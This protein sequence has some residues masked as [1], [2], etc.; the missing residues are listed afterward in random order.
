METSRTRLGCPRERF[1]Q[2]LTENWLVFFRKSHGGQ[3]IEGGDQENTDGP[4]SARKLWE[5]PSKTVVNNFEDLAVN[6]G[7]AGAGRG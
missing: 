5:S 2:N 6:D 3:P 1:L 7:T 4:P